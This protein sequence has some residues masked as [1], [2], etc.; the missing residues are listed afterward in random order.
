MLEGGTLWV[1]QEA[2]EVVAFLAASLIGG[3]LHIEEFD[4]AQ[5]FQGRGLGRRMLG[6][7]IAW[8]RIEGVS[9]L[10]LTTFSD[11]AW[12][13]PFY[14]SCGFEPWDGERPNDIEA[15][16]AHEAKMGLAPRCAMYLTL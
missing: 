2:G 10:S 7:V 15:A 14:A 13:A 12:N 9:S 8:A 11:I 16:L 5:G 4:V 3:R 6:E 1:A